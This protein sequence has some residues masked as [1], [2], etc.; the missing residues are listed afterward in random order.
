MLI[1]LLGTTRLVYSKNVVII[2][3]RKCH[4]QEITKK[5]IDYGDYHQENV[6][7]D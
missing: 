6:V 5:M 2:T 1:M 7:S 3:D 4:D